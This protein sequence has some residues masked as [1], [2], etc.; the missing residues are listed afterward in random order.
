MGRTEEPAVGVEAG[1]AGLCAAWVLSDFYGRVTVF[2]PDPSPEYPG[3]RPAI[4][5]ARYRQ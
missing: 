1:I 3:H 4:A 5:G 2:E